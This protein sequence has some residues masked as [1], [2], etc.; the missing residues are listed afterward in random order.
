[1]SIGWTAQIEAWLHSLQ[2]QNHSPHTLAA[3]RRDLAWLAD[4]Q[5][6]SK[7]ARPLFTAALR[8]LGQ[9]NQHPRSIARRLS[10]WRQFCRWLVQIGYLKANPTHGLKAPKAPERLPKAVPAEPLNQLLNQAPENPLDSR[11]LAIFELLYGSGLR[12]AEI[13][14][15]NLADLNLQSGWIAVTGKGRKQ[16]HL[17]LTAQSIRALEGYLKTR[18]A[19]PDETALFT[20]RTGHC[21]GARQIQKRLQQFAARHGSRHL[22]P[23]M[24]RH[25]Y[26]SHLLQN[27]R[28]IRAVQELLG[29]SQL[30]TTQHYTKLD[31]DHLARV[32]DDAHPRAK[33]RQGKAETVQGQDNED[34]IEK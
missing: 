19:A 12:L 16:R 21:L 3:Y 13:C 23:H 32:Y 9:Q 1:M 10:A 18:T 4:F 8:Q 33:R 29:H 2:Q 7:L 17:P 25:S 5:P 30:A 11:D 6:Q 26:A 24:L 31:F 34:K 27:A 14:A 28:D 22:S 20:G 15:L